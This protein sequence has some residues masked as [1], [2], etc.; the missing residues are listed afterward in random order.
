MLADPSSEE[1][2]RRVRL[3]PDKASV[4]E[5][6][7]CA[8]RVHVP[9]TGAQLGTHRTVLQLILE[10]IPIESF[11]VKWQPNIV[12][13]RI[14]D[15]VGPDGKVWTRTVCDIVQ[16]QVEVWWN[17]VPV[18][19]ALDP[20]VLPLIHS[21]RVKA[22]PVSFCA[23]QLYGVDDISTLWHSSAPMVLPPGM[24][25]SPVN[26]VGA[27]LVVPL[28]LLPNEY[29]EDDMITLKTGT[30]EWSV[31]CKVTRACATRHPGLA[32]ARHWLGVVVP[33]AKIC[34]KM[35]IFNDTHQDICWWATPYRW[36][37]E[38]PPSKACA[39]ADRTSTCDVCLERACTC[40]LL[41]P[42]RG[43]L[44]HNKRSRI[45]YHVHA[46]M[47]D[48]IV[49]TLVKVTRT[50]P[51]T[52]RIPGAPGCN[53]RATLLAYRVV[54][55]RLVLEVFPCGG[56]KKGDCEA[57][58]LDPGVNIQGCALLR[59][60]RVLTPCCC[61]C[62]K[63]RITNTTPIA[64]TVRWETPLEGEEFLKVKFIPNDF[65]IGSYNDKLISVILEPRRVCRRRLFVL[66]AKVAYAYKPLYLLIDTAI[67]GVRIICE[68]P[69]GG[70]ERNDSVIALRG[71][72]KETYPWDN[73]NKP[74]TPDE[75][76]EA[77]DHKRAIVQENI[78]HCKFELKY[79]PPVKS[80]QPPSF[81]PSSTEIPIVT[82]PPSLKRICECFGKIKPIVP[83]HEEPCCLQFKSIPIKTV[84]SRRL[85]LR[86]DGKVTARWRMVVRRWP[87]QKNRVATIDALTIGGDLWA[88]DVREP[89]VAIQ[90]TPAKG[91]CM[92]GQSVDILVQ[93]YADCWGLYYNQ[94]MLMVDHVEPIVVDVWIEVV[95]PV[96]QFAA[97]CTVQEFESTMWLSTSDPQ[98][99]LRVKNTS[100]S[101]LT[102]HTYTLLEHEHVQYTLPF[103][104]YMRFTDNLKPICPCSKNPSSDSLATNEESSTFSDKMYTGIE[105]YLGEDHGLQ[106][107]EYYKVGP[108]VCSVA[109]GEWKE[110]RVSLNPLI[111]GETASPG[112]VLM[113]TIPVDDRGNHWFRWEPAPALVGV[114]Q[115]PRAAV[116]RLSCR[117]VRAH[118]CALELHYNEIARVR[119]RF[120][121]RNIGT[122]PLL[123]HCVTEAPWQI[124]VNKQRNDCECGCE[125]E[126]GERHDDIE[127]MVEPWSSTSMCVEVAVDTA[128]MW[129]IVEEAH[130]VDKKCILSSYPPKREVTG[131]VVFS[132]E[133]G[134]LET[135]PLIL[136]VDFPCLSLE[137]EAIDFGF[138]THG[139]TRKTYFSVWHSSLSATITLGVT[140]HGSARLRLYPRHLRVAPGKRE[141]V[142]LQYTA[143]WTGAPV[144]IE[145][146][147]RIAAA[148]GAGAWCRGALYVRAQP[149]RDAKFSQEVHDHTDQWTLWPPSLPRL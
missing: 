9:D 126:L 141:R 38:N 40:S 58:D 48:R 87:R 13:T 138:V 133:E 115:A 15:E 29:P 32:P 139:D 50:A 104:L 122:A 21:R 8:V 117:E 6:S 2:T 135:L 147:V 55:P 23:T 62:Y 93:V 42:S 4:R 89:G 57:C 76:F 120:R 132:G 143:A 82:S 78:C 27:K 34:A 49:A 19:F 80:L 118:M 130:G 105:L 96:L 146:C 128:E 75:C 1:D 45:E 124:V 98:R 71:I 41:R 30:D 137:P 86:N 77:E 85:I 46:P 142:Y 59:P 84:R 31:S 103:R 113:R 144:P 111:G 116:L 22:V 64:T 72:Q 74:T 88:G 11:K 79:I 90:C 145:G 37:G 134:V 33:G 109:P 17:I 125:H 83:A 63:L 112:L 16:A 53:S 39:R 136:D 107:E 3:E 25:L 54:A 91:I 24:E 14:V 97:H 28:P 5:R 60:S 148:A 102:I 131:Q 67:D 119:K 56:D 140:W 106:D 149:A 101:Q 100:R 81:E 66:R 51:D 12:C 18:R 99:T 26:S 129:P 92:V 69:L 35:E 123:V 20:L 108:Q 114:R 43:S 110:W 47:T 95:G 61:S 44:A 70:G 7:A 94:I 68:V 10:N 52:A 65:E 121:M 127:L 36:T 73:T